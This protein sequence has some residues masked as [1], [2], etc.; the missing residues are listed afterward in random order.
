MLIRKRKCI[1]YDIPGKTKTYV[2]ENIFWNTFRNINKQVRLIVYSLCS[3]RNHKKLILHLF[4]LEL[5]CLD[6]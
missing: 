6:T 5:F 3:K 2:S 4:A 1:I